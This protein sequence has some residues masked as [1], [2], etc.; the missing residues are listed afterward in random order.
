MFPSNGLFIIS[1]S[2]AYVGH[3]LCSRGV[4]PLGNVLAKSIPAEISQTLFPMVRNDMLFPSMKVS[5]LL[6]LTLAAAA[7]TV[8]EKVFIDKVTNKKGQ[9]PSKIG[10]LRQTALIFDFFFHQDS[11]TPDL[12]S[13]KAR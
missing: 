2:T 13:V 5:I 11:W 9:I 10:W 6:A 8:Y 7:A 12:P 4:E 1:L 3:N